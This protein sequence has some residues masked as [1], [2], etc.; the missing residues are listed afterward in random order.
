MIVLTWNSGQ[1]QGVAHGRERRAICKACQCCVRNE[2]NGRWISTY[3]TSWGAHTPPSV[4]PH[5]VTQKG[6][7]PSR[8]AA[9]CGSVVKAQRALVR[10]TRCFLNHL[11]ALPR[12]NLT[13]TR[14]KQN[15][16]TPL[17]FALFLW[18]SL[19]LGTPYGELIVNLIT[20][21][22]VSHEKKAAFH[23]R[24]GTVPIQRGHTHHPRMPLYCQVVLCCSHFMWLSLFS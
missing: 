6:L 2:G 1:D 12:Q 13:E 17:G 19:F 14:T 15:K 23:G 10:S 9:G 7:A 11:Q 8:Q 16:Q 3:Y 20:R 5:K 24:R 4:V 21:G 18:E 22:L